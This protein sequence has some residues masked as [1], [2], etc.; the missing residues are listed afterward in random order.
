MALAQV[1]AS[2]Q[3]LHIVD[4]DLSRA[5]R[6]IRS[7]RASP[8]L[9]L[10]AMAFYKQLMEGSLRSQIPTTEKV[11]LILGQLEQQLVGDFGG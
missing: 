10:Q 9:Q 6:S 2:H 3:R 11:A 5:T 4:T 1:S 8:R 7:A